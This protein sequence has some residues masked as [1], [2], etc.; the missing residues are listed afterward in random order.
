MVIKQVVN[1]NGGT[2]VSGDFTLDSGGA[3]D[4]PDNFAGV[5]SP[6]TTVTLD[7]GSYAV[8]ESGPAGYTASYS[9]DCSGTIANGQTKTCTV[10]NNDVAPKL[11]LR[12]V[13]TNNDG[14]TKSVAD[15][16]LLA[17]G[18]GANDLSGTSPVDSG[19]GLKA[20]TWT[21][22]ETSVAGYSASAWV[23]VGGSQSGASITLA[24]G[25]EATWTITNDDQPAHLKIGRAHV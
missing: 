15:F 1:D 7:A 9:A 8:S 14:G 10:T 17:D 13:V 5:A 12:K 19:P 18:T 6:G 3:N 16:A 22:S 24:L 2:A 11:H 4:T 20:D 23:C 25:Q 21:L